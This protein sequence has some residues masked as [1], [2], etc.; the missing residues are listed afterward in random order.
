[1]KR[2][3]VTAF[4]AAIK[5][6]ASAEVALTGLRA[7]MEKRHHMSLFAPVL[8]SAVTELSH[9]QKYERAVVTVANAAD[10]SSGTVAESLKKLGVT[11]KP[12][13]TVD[14]SL[15][16]GAVVSYRHRRIDASFKTALVQIYRAIT[17]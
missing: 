5:G 16:G 1:M 3:Y 4:V 6:G 15:I 17:K 14:D 2:D 12:V 7:A 9:E 8:R 11:E 13:V 10:A